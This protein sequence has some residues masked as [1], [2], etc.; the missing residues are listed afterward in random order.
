MVIVNI[1]YTVKLN[2]IEQKLEEHIEFLNKYYANNKFICSG[3]KNPRTGG[4]ILCNADKE[5]VSEIIK[6]D[7]FYINNLGNYEIIEFEASKINK[8][9]IT[10]QLENL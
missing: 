10:K 4:V 7:P 2:K 5:E 8:E 6:E 3:R 1:T 9:L